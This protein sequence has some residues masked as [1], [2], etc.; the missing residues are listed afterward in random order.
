MNDTMRN[1]KGFTLVE[2]MIVVAIIGILGAIAIPNFLKFRL[3]AR[4][5]EATS[6][7]GGIRTTEVAY[8]AEWSRY[9][10][11]QPPTPVP[12]R[13][14]NSFKVDWDPNTN[15][16]I[17]GFTAEG[18]TFYSYALVGS[19]FPEGTASDGLTMSA[20]GDLDADGALSTIFQNHSANELIKLPAGV[21]VY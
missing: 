1:R 2:L 10:G 8:F 3:K 4:T 9:V 5:S 13:S 7:L 19:N 21:F 18:A 6:N 17:V 11:N 16:S 20:I 12:D 14:F 15:F